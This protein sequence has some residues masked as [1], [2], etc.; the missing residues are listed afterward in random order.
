MK[1]VRLVVDFRLVARGYAPL[2]VDG[3]LTTLAFWGFP[4]DLN[5]R[6][7]R[8]N[9]LYD[10]QVNWKNPADPHWHLSE[11]DRREFNA[12][13]DIVVAELLGE[14]SGAWALVV[15]TPYLAPAAE[16]ESR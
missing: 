1:E 10:R 4:R 6:L 2:V 16:D 11:R 5:R 15:D 7:E 9:L 8:L 14:L 13:L 12:L 3:T